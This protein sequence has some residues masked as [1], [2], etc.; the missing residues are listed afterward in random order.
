MKIVIDTNLLVACM[1]KK[2]SASGKIIDLAQ[3]D[4][5][6]V[7][8]HQRIRD[9]AKLITSK[10]MNAVPKA[11]IDLDK[12]FKKE[13][14]VKELPEIDG[15]SIDPDDDKFLACAIA[16]EADML[17]SN[18]KHLL[19]LKSFEGIPIYTSGNALKIIIGPTVK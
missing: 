9:E 15:G 5:V 11:K 3:K 18:D 6:I 17:V 1:F 7:M 12:V 8:W 10:I 13:N 19:D 16:G 4:L 2:S 14:E